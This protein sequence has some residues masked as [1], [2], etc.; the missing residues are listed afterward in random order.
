MKTKTKIKTAW[1]GAI[2][3]MTGLAT[4]AS[5]ANPARLNIDVTITANMSVAVNGGASSTQTVTW[6]GTPNA[7][8]ANDASSVTV[9]NDSGII[10]EKWALSTN[11]A[12]LNTVTVGGSSWTL[13]NSST[14][15]GADQFAVQA[16][17]GSS[18][19]AAAG[20]LATGAATWNNDV[21][22]PLITASPVTYTATTFAASALNAGGGTHQPDVTVGGGNGIVYGGNKRALCWRVIM[23]DS[24][25]TTEQQ[26]IQLTVTAQ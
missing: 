9:L 24:T 17:F 22:A 6:S 18:N 11:G 26:N 14:T 16:V 3:A 2:L 13:R 5:A 12:S 20:C 10:S 25:A 4:A 23:P 7:Q 1:L 8:F 21:T 19:T 15:I